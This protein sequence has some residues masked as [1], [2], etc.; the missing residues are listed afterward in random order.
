MVFQ[1][2]PDSVLNFKNYLPRE[3][4]KAIFHDHMV[5]SVSLFIRIFFDKHC[6]GT[7]VATDMVIMDYV[8][9]SDVFLVPHV[10]VI[11]TY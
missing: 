6:P 2:E 5:S 10:P 3:D 11:V 9:I 4:H 8:I 1:L 7:A